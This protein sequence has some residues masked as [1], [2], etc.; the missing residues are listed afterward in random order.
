VAHCCHVPR[1]YHTLFGEK[2]ARRE[3]RRYRRKGLGDNEKRIVDF[4]LSRGVEGAS[5]LEVGGG[6]STLQIELLKGGLERAVNVELSPYWEEEAHGLVR[7]AGVEDRWEY[8]VDNIAAD[9]TEVGPA[10][11]VI[12]HRVVC[13]DPDPDALV[14]AAAERARRYLVMSFPRE[15]AAS[16]ALVG[17]INLVARVLR[18]EHRSFVHPVATI[19][20]AAQRRG[21]RPVLEHRGFIWEIAAL[22]RPESA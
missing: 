13:C 6:V 1:G 15:R 14:G 17:L 4:L 2:A 12:M 21:L 8:R 10:D 18:W 9:D 16:Y 22:E 7:E 5:I 11:A 20:G 3:A 19:L